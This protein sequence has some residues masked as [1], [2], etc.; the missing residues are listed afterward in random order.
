MNSN[1]ALEEAILDTELR[2][3]NFFNGRLLTGGDLEAE[4]SAQHTHSWHLGM[5]V[6]AGVAFG[7]EVAPVTGSPPSEPVLI[8][9]KGLAV[10]RAG[11][12]LRLECDQQIALIRPP[13]PTTT[14]ECI[15][16]DCDPK[17]A[18]VTLASGTGF[19]VLVIA[20]ASKYEGRAPVSGLGND[21][22]L[23][24]SRYLTEGVKFR[25]VRLNVSVGTETDA[26]KIR[27]MVAYQCFGVPGRTSND[28]VQ[29]A[30]AQTPVPN[31][32]VEALVPTGYLTT[33]D[34]P[35]AVIEWNTT[36]L[37]FVDQWSVRR[38]L[39]ECGADTLWESLIGD[40]R[41]AEG[42]AMFLQFEDHIAQMDNTPLDL[43]TIV[44][45]EH[46][47][48]LPPLG[49]IP[50]RGTGSPQGFSPAQFFAA[51]AS[52]DVALLDAT[53]MRTLVAESFR[54]EP[55]SLR[56]TGKLQLYLLWESVQAVETGD[57]SQL[58]MAF[59]APTLPYRG[60]ARFGYA[61]WNLSRRTFSVV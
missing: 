2:H 30:L 60:T 25:L 26:N 57:A 23:C 35:L 22:A 46:F 50:A 11:Q 59:A 14:D 51:H 54:H 52:G 42:E 24:N 15:F 13:D 41:L 28:F 18:G 48:F 29:N 49:L 37:G 31:Y 58:I 27:N 43:S 16:N 32:G 36:G 10:N 39:T 61:K 56:A 53:E 12:T 3:I 6:G 7:L 8:V 4:Q 20:P 34:V 21:L 38:R 1:T 17:S 55:V 5:A 19:Y 40:R 44:V 47:V 33:N 45:D 9:T